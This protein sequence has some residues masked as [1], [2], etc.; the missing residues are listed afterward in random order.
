MRTR[1]VLKIIV[2]LVICAV[3]VSSGCNISVKDYTVSFDDLCRRDNLFL[4]IR[5]AYLPNE[6]LQ[7]LLPKVINHTKIHLNNSE[8]SISEVTFCN[9]I[10]RGELL[11]FIIPKNR[12]RLGTMVLICDPVHKE[13]VV[14]L[15]EKTGVLQ[16]LHRKESNFKI[17][18]FE[19]NLCL[20]EYGVNVGL[21]PIPFPW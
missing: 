3:Q 19:A 17:A 11:T 9:E 1:S 20:E 8:N 7:M 16:F 6:A 13:F 10:T 2:L 4:P 12:Q 15:E 21:S 5:E 14:L 18:L